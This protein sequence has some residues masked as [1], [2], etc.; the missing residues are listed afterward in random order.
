MPNEVLF[1][2]RI[3]DII[4]SQTQDIVSAITHCQ[5]ENYNSF[6]PHGSSLWGQSQATLAMRQSRGQIN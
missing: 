3:D 1:T 6:F 4:E 5:S 2:Q